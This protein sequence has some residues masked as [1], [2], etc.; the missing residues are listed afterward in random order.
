MEKVRTANSPCSLWLRPNVF[1]GALGETVL[2]RRRP[3]P[4]MCASSKRIGGIDARNLYAP[5]HRRDRGAVRLRRVRA[6]REKE[7]AS[8]GI[9]PGGLRV[10]TGGYEDAA[11]ETRPPSC[12][13]AHGPVFERQSI[14]DGSNRVHF[15]C[16]PSSSFD[17]QAIRATV[18]ATATPLPADSTRTA[19]ARP[20]LGRCDGY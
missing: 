16:I 20:K 13:G 12:A 5:R 15:V 6:S 19:K 18:P 9:L 2:N 8:A 10:R 11:Y 1:D 17:N 14:K 3:V 4:D 7:V